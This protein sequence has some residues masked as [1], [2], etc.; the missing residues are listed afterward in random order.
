MVV[1]CSEIFI[2]LLNNFKKN[3]I[4]HI[5]SSDSTIL[6]IAYSNFAMGTLCDALI[7]LQGQEFR[8]QIYNSK[9]KIPFI[10][11]QTNILC[12]TES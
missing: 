9:E 4:L 12:C 5:R 3:L 8:L 10:F 2:L 11:L 1:F 6:A 7:S